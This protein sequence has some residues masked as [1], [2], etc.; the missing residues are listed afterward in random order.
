M[1]IT[2]AGEYGLLALIFLA[3][4]KPDTLVMIDEICEAEKIPKVFLAKILQNLS[5]AGLVR[6]RQGA[7]GGFALNK[8]ASAVTVLEA[9]EAIEGKIA[10]QRCLEETPD[11]EK[12]DG[13][14]LCAV[15]TEAQN[16]VT[17]VFNKMTLADMMQPKE[18]VLQQCRE[19]PV[20]EATEGISCKDATD[21]RK[22]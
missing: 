10:F 20:P 22:D 5:K 3:R 12:M 4:Q 1:R 8:A 21:L 13:C 15:F 11:C 18:K 14:T 9:I 6:S 7:R 17:E 19:I 16:R 2:Q